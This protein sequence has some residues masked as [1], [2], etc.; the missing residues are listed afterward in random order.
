MSNTSDGF[1]GRIRLY[2]TLVIQIVPLIALAMNLSATN[3]YK[4][5]LVLLPFLLASAGPILELAGKR[6][7]R[8]LTV[9]GLSLQIV[10]AL[11]FVV[12]VLQAGNGALKIG[13]SDL[14]GLTLILGV[15]LVLAG[16][17]VWTFRAGRGSATA[18]GVAN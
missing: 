15:L 2:V 8:A 13:S 9:S 6:N 17:L 12:L 3:W 18:G 11:V 14:P 7:G 1:S 16:L 4:L 10:G 5:G